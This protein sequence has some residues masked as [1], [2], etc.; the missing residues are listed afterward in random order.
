MLQATGV[1]GEPDELKDKVNAEHEWSTKRQQ[2]PC[3]IK[4]NLPILKRLWKV[5]TPQER[6]SARFIHLCRRDTWRQAISQYRAKQSKV[7]IARSERGISDR[8]R[9]VPFDPEAIR[10]AYELMVAQNARWDR[11]FAKHGVEPL[12]ISYEGLCDDPQGTIQRVL[13]FLDLSYSEE[14][15]T[16]RLQVTRDEITED[17][18]QRLGTIFDLAETD[19]D[20]SPS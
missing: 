4:L 8:H 10:S 3:G 1:A 11:W 14:V 20:S 12:K 2:N 15:P 5:A 16:D 19:E 9:D 17:W 18:L 7:W 13:G 6:Q